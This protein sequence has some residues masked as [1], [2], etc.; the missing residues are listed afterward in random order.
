MRPKRKAIPKSVKATVVRRQGK[1]CICGCGETVSS[2]PRTNTHF[3]HEP[4]LRL[5]AVNDAGTDYDPPQHSARHIDARCPASHK[6]KTNGAGATTA[7]AD[8]GKIKKERKREREAAGTTKPKRKIQS[9][10]FDRRKR[11]MRGR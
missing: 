10:G 9:R 8:A 1:L 5:R 2:E 3:D 11:H 4:A 6:I 7:G